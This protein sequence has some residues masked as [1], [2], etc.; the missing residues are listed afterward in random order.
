VGSGYGERNENYRKEVHIQGG[1]MMERG[2]RR[3]RTRYIHDTG[4]EERR[5]CAPSS[6]IQYKTEKKKQNK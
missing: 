6:N 4:R 2:R 5:K 1:G 3:L